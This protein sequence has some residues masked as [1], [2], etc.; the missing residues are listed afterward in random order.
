MGTLVQSQVSRDP[1][2]QAAGT[3]GTSHIDIVPGLELHRA[4]LPDA[5]PPLHRRGEDERVS[6][7]LSRDLSHWGAVHGLHTHESY[8]GGTRVMDGSVPVA[9]RFNWLEHATPVAVYLVLSIQRIPGP[10]RV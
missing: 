6:S 3:Q 2:T 4:Q 5:D 8:R 7:R 9:C 10:A 1:R